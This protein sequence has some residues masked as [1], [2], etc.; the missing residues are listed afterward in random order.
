MVNKKVFTLLRSDVKIKDIIWGGFLFL[1]WILVWVILDEIFQGCGLNKN[2]SLIFIFAFTF[3]LGVY[4]LSLYLFS[5]SSFVLISLICVAPFFAF[6]NFNFY[7]LGGLILFLIFSG[8]AYYLIQK[9]K[10]E[11][12]DQSK[13]K[14]ILKRGGSLVVL[15]FCLIIGLVY[16]FNPLL[17]VNQEEISIS[18]ERLSSFIEPLIPLIIP[19]ISE[20]AK[21][22]GLSVNLSPEIE[23][24]LEEAIKQALVK[25]IS[26]DINANLNRFIGPY[27][28]EISLALAFGFALFF[29]LIAYILEIFSLI[30]SRLIFYV[31]YL[32]HLV[33]I[34][35]QEAKVKSVYW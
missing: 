10:R 35:E 19:D 31:L 18:E 16:Y 8:L 28:R 23:N 15:G 32:L 33:K 7:Y 22:L 17:N 11:R 3:L 6:F 2:N 25:K 24:S 9:E 29:R 21:N 26:Q 14:K 30:I 4:L 34:G 12:I 27:Q 13:L 20:L 1:C 5:F